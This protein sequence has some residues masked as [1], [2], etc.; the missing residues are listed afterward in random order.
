[1]PARDSEEGEDTVGE[2]QAPV[3]RPQRSGYLSRVQRA[4]SRPGSSESLQ[5][6]MS[7][8]GELSWVR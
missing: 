5:S 7:F 3:L 2:L 8:Q 6:Q 1:M 4:L